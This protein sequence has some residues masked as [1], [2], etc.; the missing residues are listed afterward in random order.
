MLNNTFSVLKSL[1]LDFNSLSSAEAIVLFEVLRKNKHLELLELSN[2]NIAEKAVSAISA[3]IKEISTL[4]EV[5]LDNNP[6]T[7]R[8]ALIIVQSLKDNSSIQLLWLPNSYTD[9]ETEIIKKEELSI[10]KSRKE[11]SCAQQLHVCFV[12]MDGIKWCKEFDAALRLTLCGNINDKF[13]EFEDT[14]KW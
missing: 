5:W 11:K 1:K 3:T 8:A 10:N 9:G 2:N 13:D 6:L 4:K 12:K 14:R 7:F